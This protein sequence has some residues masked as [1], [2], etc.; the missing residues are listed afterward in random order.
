MAHTSSTSD[1]PKRAVNQWPVNAGAVSSPHPDIRAQWGAFR[2][3]CHFGVDIHQQQALRRGRH[4]QQVVDE[5]VEIASDQPRRRP[6]SC[7]IV[8]GLLPK[9]LVERQLA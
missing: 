7:C 5:E 8:R 4:L 2:G 1:P 6:V 3:G 9:G